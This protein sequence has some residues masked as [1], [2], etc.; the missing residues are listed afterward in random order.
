[1]FKYS[2]IIYKLIQGL[3]YPAMLGTFFVLLF[4]NYLLNISDW[5]IVLNLDFLF[6]NFLLFYFIISFVVNESIQN[7]KIYNIGTFS[8]DVIEVIIMFFAFSKLIEIHNTNNYYLIKDFYLIC[9][10]VPITQ[11]WWNITLSERNKIFYIFN[12]LTFSLLLSFG[13]LFYKILIMNYILLVMFFLVF[14]YYLIYLIRNER[15][16]K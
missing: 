12:I 1:M 2:N 15:Q 10:F 11:T 13:L 4:Q 7:N 8:A 3:I 14:L 5:L 9:L 16:F 6:Y